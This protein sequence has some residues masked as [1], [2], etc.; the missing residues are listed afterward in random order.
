MDPERQ[1]HADE[2]PKR[3]RLMRYFTWEHLR[4][5][6]QGVSQPFCELAEKLA[7]MEGVTDEAERTVALRELLKAKDAAVRSVLPILA[8]LAV[9]FLAPS[10]SHARDFADPN[11]NNPQAPQLDASS[12][13]SIRLCVP[14]RDKDGDLYPDDTKIDCGVTIDNRNA[15]PIND[16]LPGDVVTIAIPKFVSQSATAIAVCS[17]DGRVEV[18]D[19]VTVTVVPP[20]FRDPGAP[21]LLP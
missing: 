17:V 2:M 4:P 15:P 18:G 1:T 5:E 3:H 11:C 9:L 7:G 16:A 21:V 14:N 13:G 10:Q 8:L 20:S 12:S 19:S 6:L